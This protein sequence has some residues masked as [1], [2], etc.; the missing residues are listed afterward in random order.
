MSK[1][2]YIFLLLIFV[3]ILHSSSG[4]PKRGGRGRPSN[5]KGGGSRGAGSGVV[6]EIKEVLKDVADFSDYKDCIGLIN[7][8]TQ[9]P[10]DASTN[11]KQVTF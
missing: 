7:H 9:H 5:T 2:F 8:I 3:Q 4:G 10:E 6:G 11:I 1:S